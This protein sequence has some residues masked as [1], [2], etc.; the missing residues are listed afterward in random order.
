[1]SADF[2]AGEVFEQVK[3]STFDFVDPSSEKIF[4]II[5]K[6]GEPFA[7]A[8]GIISQKPLITI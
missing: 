6:K 7:L 5:S 8:D 4:L 1:L 3:Q 2:T